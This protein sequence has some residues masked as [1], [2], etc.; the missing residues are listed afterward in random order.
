MTYCSF[1]CRRRRTIAQRA[2]PTLP[3]AECC[4]DGAAHH[5]GD[6]GDQGEHV[7][8]DED[9]DEDGENHEHEDDKKC[10]FDII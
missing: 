2:E 5:H 1:L 10:F 4:F 7:D 8:E 6:D 9:E 3:G